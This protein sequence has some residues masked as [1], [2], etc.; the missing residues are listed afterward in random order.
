M[1][2][3]PTTLWMEQP[4]WGAFISEEILTTTESRRLTSRES[5]GTLEQCVSA[6]FTR[7]IFMIKAT[8][9]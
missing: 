1:R 8:I 7:D 3:T 4:L 6:D 5:R 9:V 2:P